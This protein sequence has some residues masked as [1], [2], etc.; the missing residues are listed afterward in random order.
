MY[1]VRPEVEVVQS[2]A[3]NLEKE[4]CTQQETLGK[5]LHSR[6]CYDILKAFL[7]PNYSPFR[8]FLRWIL[9]YRTARTYCLELQLRIKTVQSWLLEFISGEE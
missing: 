4:E 2:W 6:H 9:S 7:I 3:E 1:G 8:H 5:E